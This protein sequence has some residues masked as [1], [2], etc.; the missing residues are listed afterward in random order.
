MLL[1]EIAREIWT[2]YMDWSDFLANP[3]IDMSQSVVSW[4]DYE[5]AFLPVEPRADDIARL[6]E[7]KQYSFQVIEDGGIFQFYYECTRNGKDVVAAKL[8]YYG[9]RGFSQEDAPPDEEDDGDL[10]PEGSVSPG[11][12]NYPAW[13]RIDYA[14]AQEKGVMHSCCHVHIGGFGEGRLVVKGLPSPRQF[15]ELVFQL[16]YRETFRDHR[17]DGDGKYVDEAG[18][19]EWNKPLALMDGGKTEAL[20]THLRIAGA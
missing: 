15:V 20:C 13:L 5:S 2:A 19:R 1:K 10:G 18:L 12:Q 3:R 9:V 4:Q 8:A 17:L 16:S 6:I 7:G 11:L 14:P